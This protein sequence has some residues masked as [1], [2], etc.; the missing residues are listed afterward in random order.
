M[1]KYRREELLDVVDLLGDAIDRL[2]E[3]RD[4]EQDAFD[5]MP[6]GLQESSRGDAMQD[7][8]DTL[9]GFENAI[10]DVQSRIEAYAVPK[11]KK[12]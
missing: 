3:I 11:K 6:E 10:A 7:A 4:E 1:N 12:K 5:A 2:S 9:D 8:I